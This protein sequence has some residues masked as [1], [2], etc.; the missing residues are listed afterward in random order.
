MMN[1]SLSSGGNPASASF[2]VVIQCEVCA[3]WAVRG[4]V[5]LSPSP[6]FVALAMGSGL[7][8]SGSLILVSHLA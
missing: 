2:D 5:A 4:A 8:G 3:M 7:L 6:Q 1:F